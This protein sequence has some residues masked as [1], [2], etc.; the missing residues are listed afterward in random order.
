MSNKE[1][2]P[3]PNLNKLDEQL[4]VEEYRQRY[5]QY[6]MHNENRNKYIHFY[7][8]FYFAFWGLIGFLANPE[9][10]C[11][12]KI[13]PFGNSI[14]SLL[15]FIFIVHAIF[16]SI[17]FLSIISFRQI[18]Q[19]E[20]RTINMIRGLSDTLKDK[21]KKEKEKKEEVKVKYPWDRE[22]KIIWKKILVTSQSPL[23][24]LVLLLNHL[25]FA[26]SAWLF[27]KACKHI[28]ITIPIGFT[29]I[30]GIIIYLFL[31]GK[32]WQPKMLSFEQIK[33]KLGNNC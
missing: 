9:L 21:E 6:R 10:R 19:R 26:F 29:V 7:F 15:A 4:I 28:Y 20:G 17:F 16:G 24:L 8:I 13:F 33:E 12:W 18:Q 14:E 30:F 11:F 23:V 3:N 25:S 5:Q 22:I 31:K 27:C 1:Q 2:K 32:C